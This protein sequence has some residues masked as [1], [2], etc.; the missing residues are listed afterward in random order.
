MNFR[1]ITICIAALA[2]SA[3]ALAQD[4]GS[5]GQSSQLLTVASSG[6]PGSL[7]VLLRPDVQY[8]LKLAQTQKSRI[9]TIRQKEGQAIAAAA[10]K[11]A[12]PP[13]SRR[14]LDQRIVEDNRLAESVLT[15]DQKKRLLEIKLQLRGST[16]IL[17]PDVQKEL[18]ITDGQKAQIQDLRV[19]QTAQ[20]RAQMQNGEFRRTKMSKIVKNLRTQLSASLMKLL[21]PD[22]TAKLK[23][24]TGKPF[25][26]QQ[27][28]GRG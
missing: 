10:A 23:E 4:E 25:Q 20:I 1:T 8:D 21:T 13:V 11:K 28:T 22:Q 17:D 15:D 9:E 7:Q 26:I 3:S 24:M 5:A 18:D 27:P 12:N 2:L 6:M 14:D 16:A 19:Q